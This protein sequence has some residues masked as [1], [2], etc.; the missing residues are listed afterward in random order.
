MSLAWFACEHPERPTDPWVLW[1]YAGHLS[2]LPPWPTDLPTAPRDTV[3][4]LADGASGCLGCQVKA[5]ALAAMYPDDPHVAW[6]L[7][8]VGAEAPDA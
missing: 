7:T 3:A 8:A 6:L 5:Q 1:H 2:D 4:G